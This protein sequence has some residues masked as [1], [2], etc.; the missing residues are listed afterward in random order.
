MSAPI[1]LADALYHARELVH[2]QISTI[3]FVS[4]LATSAILSVH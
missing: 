2:T 3:P 4:A 1:I